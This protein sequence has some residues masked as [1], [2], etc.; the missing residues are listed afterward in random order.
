M[1]IDQRL[2]GEYKK[3]RNKIRATQLDESIY[4]IWNY[5]NYLMNGESGFV[6]IEVSKEFLMKDY[7]Q[8]RRTLNEWELQSLL[9]EVIIHSQEKTYKPK[10]FRKMRY[11]SDS[12][13]MLKEFSN[14]VA[15]TYISSENAEKGILIEFHRLAHQQ[16][17]WQTKIAN[18][19]YLTRY[20]KIFKN[21]E[22]KE[23][24]K[25]KIG[26]DIDKFYFIVMIIYGYFIGKKIAIDYPPRIEVEN[27]AQNDLEKVFKFLCIS[28]EEMREITNR[29]HKVNQDFGYTLNQNEVFPL[30]KMDYF[31][32]K[33]LV[34]PNTR[35]LF[36]R[37]TDG[38]YYELCRENNFDRA[39]GNSFQEYIG[40]IIKKVCE[41]TDFFEEVNYGSRHNNKQSI[42]W[43]LED[44]NSLIFI[45]CKTKRMRNESKTNL[46]N[47]TCLEE[48]IDKMADFIIQTYKQ[49]K[50]Y[51]DNLYS[52]CK[53]KSCKKIYPLIVTLEEWY[54]F[55]MIYTKVE[56]KVKQKLQDNNLPE[57]FLGDFPFTV[58][59]VDTFEGF[60]QL[61][62]NAGIE[63][64][65][66]KKT[67][68]P[69]KEYDLMVVLKNNF[70]EE[71]KKTKFLF[72][73]D[74]EKILPKKYY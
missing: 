64:V 8:R 39:F 47:T 40:E 3:I 72:E 60:I 24:V 74:F 53:Y 45:E 34:C 25:N 27:V 70:N 30:I 56:E 22:V 18:G 65:M 61:I 13:N 59:S 7:I 32:K 23:I 20:A 63:K 67:T 52:H 6:D 73:E 15:K 41:K 55:G 46:T 4:V 11:F 43:L 14:T 17:S 49:I 21:N 36:W 5:L 51:K 37:I 66:S 2:W 26:M 16:F 12:I 68:M 50:D 71:M 48:D 57:S 38:L 58:C 62:E 1:E 9:R 19:I 10:S 31:G 69:E 54:V 29:M 44:D 28:I 35:T 33:S 42:D